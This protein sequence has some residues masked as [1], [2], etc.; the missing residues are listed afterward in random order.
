MD[1]SGREVNMSVISIEPYVSAYD[2]HYAIFKF[3]YMRFNISIDGKSLD[4]KNLVVEMKLLKDSTHEGGKYYI[5]SCICGEYGC[6]GFAEPVSIKHVICENG[7]IYVDW[8]YGFDEPRYARFEMEQ[9]KNEI[10]SAIAKAHELAR[11]FPECII[12]I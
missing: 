7:K 1:Y 2:P 10:Y 12:Y 5:F 4:N 3:D 6:A 11:K 9:Y 8:S